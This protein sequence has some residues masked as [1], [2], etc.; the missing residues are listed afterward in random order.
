MRYLVF[1]FLLSFTSMLALAQAEFSFNVAEHDFGQI[2]EKKMVR[3]SISSSMKIL[4]M[5]HC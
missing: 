3:W 5:S 4:E 1:T 2:K